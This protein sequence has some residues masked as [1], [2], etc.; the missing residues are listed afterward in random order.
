[1]AIALFDPLLA[2]VDQVRFAARPPSQARGLARHL[3]RKTSQMTR[4]PLSAVLPLHLRVNRGRELCIRSRPGERSLEHREKMSFVQSFSFH[5]IQSSNNELG[6]SS[7]IAE[8][9][10]AS[11]WTRRFSVSRRTDLSKCVLK[12]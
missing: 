8:R 6:I 11:R 7:L 10:T 2:G 4:D 9:R 1:M 12:T 5:Q 3:S